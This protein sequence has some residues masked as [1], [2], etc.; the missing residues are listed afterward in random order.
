MT[1]KKLSRNPL[2]KH[3]LLPSD[4]GQQKS[5]VIDGVKID[6]G[7]NLK[8]KTKSRECIDFWCHK[9]GVICLVASTICSFTLWILLRRN[10]SGKFK[11]F[12]SVLVLS[13]STKDF[14]HF[15]ASF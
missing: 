14:L 1:T 15:V 13:K 12:S 2:I 6:V 4:E 11:S 5:S 7:M 3:V 10:S 8:S 9:L